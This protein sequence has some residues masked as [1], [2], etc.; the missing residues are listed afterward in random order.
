MFPQTHHVENV[1]LLEKKWKRIWLLITIGIED[2]KIWKLV[3][4]IWILRMIISLEVEKSIS[5]RILM[6]EILFYNITLNKKTI[7]PNN[8]LP[9]GIR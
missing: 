1:V 3:L 7:S 4:C 9:K 8:S 2:Q 6:K 5:R